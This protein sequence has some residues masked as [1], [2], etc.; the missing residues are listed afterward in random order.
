MRRLA[1]TAAVLA[2]LLVTACG[3]SSPSGV[4][5]NPPPH[6]TSGAGSP[7]ASP[8]AGGPSLSPNGTTRT[9]LAPLGLNMR[10]QASA[11]S[12]LLGTLGQGTLVTV[13]GHSAQGG[14]WY[15]VR[16]AT[17][18]GWIR[19]DPAY[20]SP[21]HFLSYQSSTTGFSALYPD[22]WTFAESTSA[23]SFRPQSGAN[24]MLVSVGA[25]LA[26][27]GQP[28]RAGYSAVTVDSI[29]VYGITGVLRM[30]DRTGSPPPPTPGVFSN[31]AHLAEIRATI[32]AQR[33]IR[34]DYDYDDATALDIFHDIVNS[35]IIPPSTTTS[36]AATSS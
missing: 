9:I 19:D 14:G 20:S 3:S 24:D 36:T 7:T 29:E 12:A 10:A 1:A 28:G 26:A 17:T 15:N 22:T 23:V 30:Y 25:N 33:A 27:L 8:A 31:L 21:R 18:T 16:G 11:Q 2:A 32:D 13:L 4:V 5:T 34:I 6:Q 35:I